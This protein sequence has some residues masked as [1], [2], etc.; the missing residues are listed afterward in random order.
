MLKCF[1]QNLLVLC[2]VAS[3]TLFGRNVPLTLDVIHFAPLQLC[4]TVCASILNF[5]T[6][7]RLRTNGHSEVKLLGAYF[8]SGLQCYPCIVSLHSLFLV[9]AVAEL[10]DNAVDEVIKQLYCSV[11]CFDYSGWNMWLDCIF[12]KQIETSGAT[13][14]VVDKVTDNR[15]GLPALLVQ[16]T[17]YYH[18]NLVSFT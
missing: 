10:L 18:I 6:P 16:G 2:S 15:N 11:T 3:N 17:E 5:Y 14:I 13:R 4:K 7:T 1:V 8:F 9:P 12:V